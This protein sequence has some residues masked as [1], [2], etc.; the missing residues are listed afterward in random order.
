MIVVSM[1]KCPPKLRGDLSKWLLEINTGVYVGKV[2]ARVRE[3]LWKRV[4]EN[5]G[6]GQATMVFTTNNE[7]HMDFYVHNTQWKPVD[8]D[9]IKLMKHLEKSSSPSQNE[10][11]Y[12]FSNEAKRRMGKRRRRVGKVDSYVILDVETTGLS[13]DD[14][15]IIEIGAIEVCNGEILKEFESLIKIDRSVPDE[16]QKLTG[17]SDQMIFEN[18]NDLE[19][20]LISL[21]DF[22]SDKCLMAYNVS[23]DIGFIKKYIERYN[24]TFPDVEVKDALLIARNKLANLKNYKLETVS[25][26]L[27]ICCSQTHRA[28]DDCKLL[29]EVYKKLNEI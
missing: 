18:G 19:N 3:A 26:Y 8:F 21:L 12:G 23:F 24:L 14:D 28:I 17:I 11:S 1:T 2:S 13:V 15:D 25:E 6:D 16:I 9:G 20:V 10:L 27:G 4:C 22:I 29:N 7:Q 5:I